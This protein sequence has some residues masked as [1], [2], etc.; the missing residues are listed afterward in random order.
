[1][2]SSTPDWRVLVAITPPLLGDLLARQLDRDD[3]EIVVVDGQSARDPRER[4]YDFFDVVITDDLPPPRVRADA[5]L[6]LHGQSGSGSGSLRT[7]DGV[8][9]IVIT[10]LA[11]IVGL[12]NRLCVSRQ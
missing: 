10:E 5:V 7:S 3:V 11:T 12:V 4:R 2:R 9:H 6:R 1:M 8:E